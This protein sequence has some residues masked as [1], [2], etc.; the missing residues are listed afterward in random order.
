MDCPLRDR[1]VRAVAVVLVSLLAG[2]ASP[3]KSEPPP[4][5]PP[6]RAELP[7]IKQPE[8]TPKER[9]ALHME[10]GAG[11]YQR[12]QMDV[13]L[14]ELDEA[15]K[16]DASN[17]RIYNVYGLVYAWIGE[18]AKAEQNF[19]RALAL[20]PQDSEIRQNWG[21]FLCTSGRARQS[22]AEFDAAAANPLYKTPEIALVNAGRCSAS[23]GDVANAEAYFKRAIAL[24]PADANAAFGLAQLA[25]RGNRLGEARVWMRR[26]M[27]QPT[28]TPEALFLGMC[29][30]RGQ[31][32]RE[33]ELSYVAQLR[34]RY[35][36]AA[37]TTAIATGSCE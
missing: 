32:D 8:V 23:F 2:C 13:A 37:E 15:V 35:P 25:Y 33:A 27:A 30:E 20:A 16:L 5:A 31:G 21:W 9:A 1:L 34:N 29:I 14:E 24:A 22:I 4:P 26:L 17:A 12:G 10:L 6:P 11:Y 3:P 28:P 36:D 18:N 7:P 19:Q